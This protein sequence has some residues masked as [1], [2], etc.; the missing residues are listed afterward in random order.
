MSADADQLIARTRA[1][2]EAPEQI[3]LYSAEH[4]QGPTELESSLL[5]RLRP[6][7]WDIL[8]LGCGAGRLAVPLALQGNRVTGIDVSRP[9]IDAARQFAR[10]RD[11]G[12]VEFDVVAGAGIE[13][14]PTSF[15]LVL[16]VKHFCY[17]PGR[18]RRRG[19]LNDVATVLRPGGRLVVTSHL[20]PTEA[21]A[22]ESLRDDPVHRAAAAEFTELEPLDTFSDGQGYVHW[23]T[24]GSL[25]DELSVFGRI[26]GIEESMDGF[27]IGV[28]LRR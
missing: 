17:I 27:Q 2:F 4:L 20:V 19:L 3:S 22:L 21:E 13:F 14:P 26:E 25:L 15:D 7:G 24:R 9:L 12:T 8:D 5:E 11:A 16:S 28:I 1:W 23:F 10:D 6:R 18:E